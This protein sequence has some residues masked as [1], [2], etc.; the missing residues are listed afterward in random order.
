MDPTQSIDGPSAGPDPAEDEDLM[1]PFDEEDDG[2][3]AQGP[4]EGDA[5]VMSWARAM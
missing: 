3:P 5:T 4:G 2:R 1:Q